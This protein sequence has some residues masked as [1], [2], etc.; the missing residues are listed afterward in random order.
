[1]KIV[2]DSKKFISET[3]EKL[4]KIENND[5]LSKQPNEK[6][7]KKKISFPSIENP[8]S[9]IKKLLTKNKKKKKKSKYIRVY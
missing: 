3:E 5:K 4:R 7:K 2:A 9:R 1:M 6:P 8:F